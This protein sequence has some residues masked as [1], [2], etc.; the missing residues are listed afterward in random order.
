MPGILPMKLIKVGD[1]SH[2]EECTQKGLT[3]DHSAP[4]CSNCRNAGLQCKRL[5]SKGAQA[6]DRC[7]SKHIRCD[8]LLP[9]CTQCLN[10]GF[11]CRTSEKLSR[12]EFPRGYTESL[13]ERVRGLESETRDLKELLDEKD[14]N[15]DALVRLTERWKTGTTKSF[16]DNGGSQEKPP[17]DVM[18][19]KSVY[20][21]KNELKVS[22]LEMTRNIAVGESKTLKEKNKT[23]NGVSRYVQHKISLAK[24]T[25]TVPSIDIVIVD[26]PDNPVD[27]DYTCPPRSLYN[28]AYETV[29]PAF[30]ALNIPEQILG[31]YG[32]VVFDKFVIETAQSGVQNTKHGS[33]FVYHISLGFFSFAFRYFPESGCC[34]GFLLIQNHKELAMQITNDLIAYRQFIGEPRLLPFVAQRAIDSVLNSWFGLQKEAIVEAQR[35]TGYHQ[36]LSLASKGQRVDFTELSTKVTGTAM[37]IA[38]TELCWKLLAEHSCLLIQELDNEVNG[39]LSSSATSLW[40]VE[41][42]TTTALYR[43]V[44][45]MERNTKLTLLEVNSW[46]KKASI[47]VQGIF[48]LI[49]QEDQNTSIGIARDSHILAAESKR[50]STSMKTIAVVTMTFLPGTFVA[51]SSGV[52]TN[53]GIEELS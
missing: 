39:P 40:P 44:L 32:R 48:N 14:E 8:G 41:L 7:R 42:S 18:F 34:V 23:E 30:K 37:N 24:N 53:N 50:D 36:M 45:R 49:A 16:S 33:A 47:M 3:C 43:E 4:R 2:C 31:T 13:E 1:G 51:V 27:G 22:T 10:V 35:Q 20:P 52:R 28:E 21:T 26:T 12:R 17:A 29:S 9:S 5:Q 11:Q 38:T 15:I 25:N 46:Q 19:K 6:C